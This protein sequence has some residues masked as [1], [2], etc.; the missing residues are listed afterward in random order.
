MSD[1]SCAPPLRGRGS[2]FPT[3]RRQF[4]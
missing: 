4:L 3:A 2:I 1:A